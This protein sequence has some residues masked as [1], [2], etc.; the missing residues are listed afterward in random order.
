ME[1]QHKESQGHRRRLTPSHSRLHK[2]PPLQQGYPCG[3][4]ARNKE[5]RLLKSR[6]SSMLNFIPRAGILSF[7]LSVCR[8]AAALSAAIILR[9]DFQREHPLDAGAGTPKLAS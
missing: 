1:T 5:S 3:I 6:L 4:T 8:P 7:A 9:G 2:M